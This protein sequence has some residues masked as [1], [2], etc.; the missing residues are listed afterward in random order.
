MFALCP[1]K[2]VFSARI[3]YYWP[4][5]V[6]L[7]TDIYSRKR[8]RSIISKQLEN[9]ICSSQVFTFQFSEMKYFGSSELDYIALIK[10]RRS[11]IDVLSG[12]A[13]FKNIFEL[14]ISFLDS[15]MKEN[16]VKYCLILVIHAIN[17]LKCQ[18]LKSKISKGAAIFKPRHTAKDLCKK[19]TRKRSCSPSTVNS[20]R[21]IPGK[22]RCLPNLSAP[23]PYSS[24]R[25]GIVNTL[26]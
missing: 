4:F 25:A 26:C 15:A 19:G 21:L 11:L 9:G 20:S 13:E 10:I 12:S 7:W 8:L 5:Q 24:H 1:P 2:H 6:S 14:L 18:V 16:G 17:I 22:N 23:A 3:A